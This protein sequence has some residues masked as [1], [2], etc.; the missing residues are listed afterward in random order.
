MSIK[1]APQIRPICELART[2]LS[3]ADSSPSQPVSNITTAVSNIRNKINVVAPNDKYQVL[4]VRLTAVTN[5]VLH[6]APNIKVRWN[7]QYE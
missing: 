4:P 2:A 3:V 7:W 1:Y 5:N 6:M